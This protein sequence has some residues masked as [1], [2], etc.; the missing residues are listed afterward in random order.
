MPII[1]INKDKKPNLTPETP[2]QPLGGYALKPF[3]IEKQLGYVPTYWEKPST[4]GRYYQAMKALQPGQKPPDWMDAE[5]LTAA[6]KYLSYRN[7]GT[8]WYQWRFLPPDDPG[9]GYLQSINPPPAEYLW[10]GED[11]FAARSI[12]T[13][14]EIDQG[15]IGPSGFVSTQPDLTNVDWEKLP[16]WQKI[17]YTA[18]QNPY[19]S[20]AITMLPWAL[21]GAASGMAVGGPIGA[22]VG[23]ASPLF[24]G[25]GLSFAGDP[26]TYEKLAQATNPEFAGA[27]QGASTNVLGLLNYPAEWLE[28]GIGT[29]SM[30]AGAKLDPK[31][32]GDFQDMLN[33]LPAI[34][35]ASGMTYESV[36]ANVPAVQNFPAA[37]E[38]LIDMALRG[39]TDVRFAHKGEVQIIGEAEPRKLDAYGFTA[40]KLATSEIMAGGDPEYVAAKYADMFGF[41]GQF[42]DLV[43]QSGADPFNVIPII[44]RKGVQVYAKLTGNPALEM[45]AKLAKGEGIIGTK[46]VYGELLRSGQGPSIAEMTPRQ[47]RAAGLTNEGVIKDLQAGGPNMVRAVG[48]VSEQ[49][50]NPVAWYQA[51]KELTPASRARM[52]LGL[53]HENIETLLDAAKFEPTEMIRLVRS[54]SE[55]PPA[56]A[57]EVAKMLGFPEASTVRQALTDFGPVLRELEASWEMGGPKRETLLEVA[58]AIGKTPGETLEMMRSSKDAAV[59]HGM[60]SDAITARNLA[61]GMALLADPTFTPETIRQTVEYFNSNPW[62]PNDFRGRLH[63]ALLEHA[64]EWTV[65]AYGVRPDSKFLRFMSGLKSIQSLLLLGVNPAYLVNNAVNNVVTRAATGVF[66]FVDNRTITKFFDDFGITPSRLRSGVGAADIG[67]DPNITAPGY[68]KGLAQAENVLRS[69]SRG[70]DWVQKFQ[71]AADKFGKLGPMS[72]LASANERYESANAMYSGVRQAWAQLWNRKGVIPNM[73]PGV[74]RALNAIDPRL[75]DSIV[76]LVERGINVRDIDAITGQTLVQRSIDPYIPAVAENLGIPDAEL[77]DVMVTSGAW[78]A[79]NTA[80]EQGAPITDAFSRAD[81]QVRDYLDQRLGA[82]LIAR[83]GDVEAKVRSE[84]FVAALDIFKDLQ[85]KLE[86]VWTRHFAEWERTYEIAEGID[87]WKSRNALVSERSRIQRQEFDSYNRWVDATYLGIFRALGFTSEIGRLLSPDAGSFMKGLVG[88]TRK[89]GHVLRD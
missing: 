73:N 77:R 4:V 28:K 9:R 71:D 5:K 2:R 25:A 35:Q 38:Y 63:N 46:R 27:I 40:L 18:Q 74:V 58:A 76:S 10:P 55:L 80:L 72:R 68:D 51:M 14:E 24:A 82:D 50:F 56:Q 78:T 43:F 8:P 21:L 11:V 32:Y 37:I 29:G 17:A 20:G 69:A 6:Y 15:A 23:F 13:K 22:A 31:D 39:E 75:A 3:H 85:W 49:P 62:H 41:G 89:L 16:A 66:G 45:A 81:S 54:W 86:E 60:L 1:P 42:T 30:I 57:M 47:I 59:V 33:N 36:A 19:A 34:W 67:I 44:E 70:D 65:K 52:F 79:I 84:G 83:A 48:A 7:K 12:K 53:A 26:A 87:N 88:T 64:A 61:E